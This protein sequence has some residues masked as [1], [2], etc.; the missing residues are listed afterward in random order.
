MVF[1][2]RKMPYLEQAWPFSFNL[3]L[4]Y[5]KLYAYIITNLVPENHFILC[6]FIY[7]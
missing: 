5:E 4:T 2:K 7:F 3:N 6:F 1:L